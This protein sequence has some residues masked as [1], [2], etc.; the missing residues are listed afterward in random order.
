M[1]GINY[2]RAPLLH[3]PTRLRPI[4]V[5]TRLIWGLRDPALGPWFAEASRYESWVAH[6]DRVLLQDV[7][8][9]PPQE[10]AELVNAALRE[11]FER[12][13]A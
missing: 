11:H 2:Y 8:H 1:A 13:A 10:A 9:F 3:M 12:R 5:P 4:S 7:G 6:F